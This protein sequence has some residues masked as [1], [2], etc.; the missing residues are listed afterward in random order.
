MIRLKEKYQSQV[1]SQ[2]SSRFSYG[3]AHQVPK[4]LKVVLNMGVGEAV[5]NPKAIEEASSDLALIAGQSPIVRRARQSIASFK[6][7]EGMPIGVSVTLRN[8]RMYEFVER[9]VAVAL[10]RV[11]DFRGIPRKSFD[12]RGNYSLGI[13]EQI[14]FP[15]INL[16]KSKIRGLNIN[17][18]TSANTNE[19]GFA[20]LEGLGLPFRKATKAAS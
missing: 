19:E 2:L 20:L 17:F 3:N 13:S 6:L 10:P 5:Q 8:D 18:V 14:I 15:E 4:L 1:I 9:L 12:G 11:R 16:D 7:R